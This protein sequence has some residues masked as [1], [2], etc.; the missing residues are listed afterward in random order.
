VKALVL[1]LL[2]ACGAPRDSGVVLWHSYTG[3]ERVAL[4]E[5]AARWNRAHADKPLTLVFVPDEVFADKLSSAIPRGN[6]PDLFIRAHDRIGNWVDAGVLEP[7]EYW[8][9]D[10]RA[11]H[12]TDQALGAMAYKDSL[13][14]LPLALKSLVLFYRTDLVAS[15]PATTDELVRMKHDDRVVL[16]YANIDLY[17]HAAWLHGFGG[18][19]MDDTGKLAIASPEAA[20]AME[21]ARTL[22]D[23][24]VIP[25]DAQDPQAQAMFN[26][27]TAAMVLQGPWFIPNIGKDVPWKVAPLPIVSATGK[28]AAPFLTVEGVLMSAQAHDKDTA[29][30]V[31]EE[32]TSDAN[33]IVRGRTARQVVA[34]RAAWNDPELANDPVLAVLRAQV[35]NTVVTPKVKAMRSV[36]TPY[37]TALGKVLT[38]RADAGAELLSVETEVKGYAERR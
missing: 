21:F 2:V 26:D 20:R 15:P 27:G 10:A 33:A 5:T 24:H 29:F 7:I 16:A 23:Q 30:A 28:P 14:G 1:A 34:N 8:V 13:Y 22:V 19:V 6:G 12:F 3:A 25:A 32:L 38:G 4:E 11:D 31:M 18:R 37:R 9:D 36:W 17:G 35:A